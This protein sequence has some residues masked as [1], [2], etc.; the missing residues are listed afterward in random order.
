MSRAVEFG[1]PAAAAPHVVDVDL[2]APG[3]GEV[4]VTVRAAG[5]TGAPPATARPL[6][7]ATALLYPGAFPGG[8]S[9]FAGVVTAL[10]RGVEDVQVGDEVLGFSDTLAGQADA[11]VVPAGHVVRKPADLSWEVAG[12]LCVAGAAA[13]ACVHAAGVRDG[14]TVV[15]AGACTDVGSF[16]VQLA[17]LCGARV[18]GVA[19][20]EHHD[21]LLAHGMDAVG[22]AG[23][24]GEPAADLARRLAAAAP[25]GVDAFVDT[26][27]G[28]GADVADALGVPAHRTVTTVAAGAG[29][30]RDV[31]GGLVVVGGP[32]A[33]DV[34]AELA[35]L[36]ATGRLQV[37][38]AGTYPLES[39]REAYA[40]VDEHH[41]L[42]RVV[43]LP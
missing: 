26:L 27:G 32:V 40:D 28:S 4:R 17:R 7:P 10:G 3:P 11:V 43:L 42:G 30:G 5:I 36:V 2:A 8:G 38:I 9:D 35:E 23:P 25:E 21:W 15:V 20:P 16:V 29:D 18:I 6:P 12:S 31:G 37:P 1:G 14:D 22:P 34:L 24:E 19:A 39:V 33:Q 41:P 13:S